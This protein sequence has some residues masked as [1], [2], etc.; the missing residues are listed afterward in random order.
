MDC[1]QLMIRT[2]PTYRQ[3]PPELDDFMGAQRMVA[4]KIVMFDL[5]GTDRGTFFELIISL[6]VL[7]NTVVMSLYYFESPEKGEYVEQGSD[8]FDDLQDTEWRAT[9]DLINDGFTAVF[10]MEMLLKI[11][12]FGA[13]NYWRDPWNK[14]DVVV[15]FA[16]LVMV[17]VDGFMGIAVVPETYTDMVGNYMN[18]DPKTLRVMRVVKL[19]RV[20]R[21]LKGLAKYPRIQAA[22]QLIDTLNNCIKHMLNVFGLWMLV[23]ITFALMSMSL[24]GHIDIQNGEVYHYGVIGEYTNFSS[25][26]QVGHSILEEEKKKNIISFFSFFCVPCLCVHL[27]RSIIIGTGGAVQS[28]DARQL[29]VADARRN[30]VPDERGRASFRVGLLRAVLNRHRLP[31]PQ[32]LHRHRHGS[33]RLHRAS[34]L[35][36]RRRRRRRKKKE[37]ADNQSQ[38][39]SH[40][41]MVYLLVIVP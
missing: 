11:T 30:E 23:T 8:A 40:F 19:V 32:Y 36:V 29:D 35:T 3:V 15:V 9:L 7:A 4:Y 13:K 25:F 21:L 14:F 31:L 26:T 2:R 28:G 5:D 16:S 6:L 38:I 18:F 37:S 12:A 34:Y 17:A 33:V 24:F 27:I 39:T 10:V 20:V 22:T 41:L 1:L